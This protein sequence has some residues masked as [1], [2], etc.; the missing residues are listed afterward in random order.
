MKKIVTLFTITLSVALS[1]QI[2]FKNN[3]G[4]I[5]QQNFD[6][7]ASTGTANTVMPYG[8]YFLET[9]S[10]LNT[11]YAADIGSNAGGNT[12]SYGA[13][14]S[15]DRALG[16]LTTNSLSSSFGC[17]FVNKTD[18]PIV[19]LD[20]DF[21][22]EQWRRGTSAA[23]SIIVEYSTDA[24]DLGTGTWTKA[25]A[26]TINSLFVTGNQ[27]AVDGNVNR[28][29]K[30]NII[31]GLNIPI[32]G[33]IWIRFSSVNVALSDEGLAIDDLKIVARKKPSALSINE[34]ASSVSFTAYPN[35][36]NNEIN[37]QI[38]ANN[39]SNKAD[40]LLYDITGK[41]IFQSK[42]NITTNN[43]INLNELNINSGLVF[44][45][46]ITEDGATFTRKLMKQ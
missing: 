22:V 43:K 38:E 19:Q 40:V 13:A 27:G 45:R 36:F 10:T 25:N 23:D 9:G 31:Q 41:L 12:Y 6:S 32:N 14:A 16:E 28:M 7:L 29:Q 3:A 17:A 15:T 18:S 34:K 11:T 1:A 30:I 8:W 24:A 33:A 37:L 35:P 42:I 46:L 21:W 20:F 39:V 2:Q 5:Y 4:L 44:V 26:L